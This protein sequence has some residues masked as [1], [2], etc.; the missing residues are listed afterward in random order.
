MNSAFVISRNWRPLPF[1]VD[2]IVR[3]AS[4]SLIVDGV[5]NIWSRG[6]SDKRLYSFL[7]HYNDT[8]MIGRGS[9]AP[10]HAMARMPCVT[11]GG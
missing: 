4:A 1:D 2:T 10:G 8:I 7:S 9:A 11:H 3:F 5:L 6:G